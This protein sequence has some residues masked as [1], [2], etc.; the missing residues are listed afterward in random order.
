[1]SSDIVSEWAGSLIW[2]SATA[3]AGNWSLATICS[4]QSHDGL[5][6]LSLSLMPSY[7]AFTALIKP[8]GHMVLGAG[9]IWGLGSA[10]E[11]LP[12]SQV[13]SSDLRF[14]TGSAQG[15]RGLACFAGGIMRVGLHTSRAAGAAVTAVHAC[16]DAV[17]D[18]LPAR[19]QWEH[20]LG[21]SGNAVGQPAVVLL[22]VNSPLRA[23]PACTCMQRRRQAMWRQ[24]HPC[25]FW[26]LRSGQAISQQDD[27]LLQ[28]RPPKGKCM[29]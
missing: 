19:D 24:R 10:L 8:S 20:C 14:D 29:L 4:W 22:L 21:D 18:T 26:P 17:A 5:H 13:Q 3:Y 2:A 27:P 7:Q 25:F 12:S 9:R 1:M 6:V 11:R 15:L 16:A 28:L 23:R